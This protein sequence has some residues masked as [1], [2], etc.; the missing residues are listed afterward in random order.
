MNDF[1]ADHENDDLA[2]RLAHDP[3]FADFCARL[4]AEAAAERMA[5]AAWAGEQYPVCADCPF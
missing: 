3:E 1:D 2:D 4:D 5:E